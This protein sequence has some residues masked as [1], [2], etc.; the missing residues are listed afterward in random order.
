MSVGTDD[1][2]FDDTV[3]FAPR[4]A[5]AGNDVEVFV[6]PDMPHGFGAFPC[7]ISDAWRRVTDDWLRRVLLARS[8]DRQQR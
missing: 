7:G 1:H 2:L 5:A 6:A 8:V 3:M 4:W